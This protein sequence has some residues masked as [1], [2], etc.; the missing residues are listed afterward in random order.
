MKC[1]GGLQ[2]SNSRSKG[3]QQQVPG[4]TCLTYVRTRNFYRKKTQGCALKNIFCQAFINISLYMTKCHVHWRSF[5]SDSTLKPSPFYDSSM[6]PGGHISRW[7]FQIRKA[8]LPVQ[9]VFNSF[10][11]GFH[12][13]MTILV[14]EKPPVAS[15]IPASST[16]F[17]L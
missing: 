6:K 14:T 17:N 13:K 2:Y 7:L 16:P 11:Q 4:T 9:K 12:Q 3:T 15:Q 5:Y 10:F 8:Q 1:W